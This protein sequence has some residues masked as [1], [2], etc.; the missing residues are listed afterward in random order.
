[1]L[2][3]AKEVET[4][5][6]DC[7][8]GPEEVKEN[9]MPAGTVI[10]EGIVGKY[11]FHPGRLERHRRQIAAWLL[12]LPVEFQ[13]SGGGGWSFLNACND[14]DGAQWADHHRSM[15]QLFCLRIGLKLVHLQVPRDMWEILP[16]GMPYYTV[17]DTAVQSASESVSPQNAGGMA[18]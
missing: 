14:R 3:D 18:G 10:V 4:V 13:Q 8:F 11:G 16:G 12:A 5:F 9:S 6:L 17:F 2:I 7:L 15:E 1:M